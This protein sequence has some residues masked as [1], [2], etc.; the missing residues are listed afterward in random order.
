MESRQRWWKLPLSFNYFLS[1]FC[2]YR[3]MINKM[4]R[5]MALTS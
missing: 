5:V 3:K 2:Y 4:K 1:G